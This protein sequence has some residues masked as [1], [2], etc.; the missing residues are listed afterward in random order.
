MSRNIASIISESSASGASQINFLDRAAGGGG[1]GR[2]GAGRPEPA[3]AAAAT[4]A[5]A[6]PG[7]AGERV[8]GWQGRDTVQRVRAEYPTAVQNNPRQ[9]DYAF[10]SP[11]ALAALRP[12]AFKYQVAFAPVQATASAGHGEGRSRPECAPTLRLCYVRRARARGAAA[13][14]RPFP[15]PRAE[16]AVGTAMGRRVGTAPSQHLCIQYISGGSGYLT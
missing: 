9:L 15:A 1:R 5:E 16:A 12:C 7:L 4:K 11:L 2:I 13:R 6:A 14:L 8:G 3:A 10:A